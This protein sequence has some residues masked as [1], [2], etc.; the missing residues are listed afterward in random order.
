MSQGGPAYDGY[1]IHVKL[2][3]VDTSRPTH[4]A[5]TEPGEHRQMLARRLG[6][7]IYQAAL[8]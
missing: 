6:S 2:G 1:E 7:P 4:L 5:N 3:P 8:F